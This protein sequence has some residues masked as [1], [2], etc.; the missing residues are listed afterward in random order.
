MFNT[1][2]PLL[3]L[4]VRFVCARHFCKI[5]LSV[6][7]S[8]YLFLYGIVSFTQPTCQVPRSAFLFRN[9]KIIKRTSNYLFQLRHIQP[10]QFFP[11]VEHNF[12]VC[13]E[14]T[15]IGPSW[16]TLN[17]LTH[18]LIWA[19][20]AAGGWLSSSLRVFSRSVGI[21]WRRIIGRRS[22]IEQRRRCRRR[23]EHADDYRWVRAFWGCI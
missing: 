21:N 7:R 19:R 9:S 4:T 11:D 18:K 5:W 3:E 1:C 12:E 6:A 22:W 13:W 20:G 17:F 2:E 10:E 23:D 14:K 16:I 15:Y 8:V